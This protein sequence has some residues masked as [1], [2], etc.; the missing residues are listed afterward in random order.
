MTQDYAA[1]LASV[2]EAAQRIAPF[3]HLTPVR[4]ETSLVGNG[5][6]SG[7]RHLLFDSERRYLMHPQVLTNSTAN[8]LAGRE[9]FFKCEVFQRRC[10]GA[11]AAATH[12]AA[13]PM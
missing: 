6:G 9:L 11:F 2:R 1:S 8:A 3:A 5:S 13:A 12:A 4:D 10:G 7:G